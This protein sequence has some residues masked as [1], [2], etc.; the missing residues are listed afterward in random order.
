MKQEE[1]WYVNKNMPGFGGICISRRPE[2][3]YWLDGHV[4]IIGDYPIAR[5]LE[6]NPSWDN[7]F[8][9]E[10][11]AKRM[12]AVPDLIN[13]LRI[14]IDRV[15]SGWD[16]FARPEQNGLKTAFIAEAKEALKKATE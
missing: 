2:S 13:A 3:D 12:A 5:V 1:K 15:E 9:A 16:T 4:A 7:K 11:N 8:N 6:G 14:I 10:A